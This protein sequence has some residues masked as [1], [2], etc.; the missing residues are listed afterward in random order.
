MRLW[1]RA[2]GAFKD[3]SS[4]WRANLTRRTFL[5]NPDIDKAI[6]RATSHRDFS[7]SADRHNLDIVCEWLRLS[8]HNLKPIL[9]SLSARMDRTRSWPVAL[10]GL[11]LTHALINCNSS[12]VS[13]IGRLPFDLSA[14]RDAHAPRAGAWPLNAFVRAY[15]AFL[16]QKSATAFQIAG[17]KPPEPPSGFAM[18]RELLSLQRLQ[19]LL[20]LLLAIKP[21]STA[22]FVPL[23]LDVMDGVIV[24]IYDVYGRICRGIAMVLLNIYSAG[25]AEAAVALAVVNKATKQGEDL[26]YFFQFCQEIRVVNAANFPAID[27]IPEEGIQ[28]LEQ[29][30]EELSTSDRFDCEDDDAIV[31]KES[32]DMDFYLKVE[33]KTVITDKWEKF[34]EDL[35]AKTA[36]VIRNQEPP[37]LITFV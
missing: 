1:K 21:A 15:Y 6:I 37:D 19:A 2:S 11:L 13:A 24:E 5:R 17:E 22:A 7:S 14:F 32:D 20:D 3:Q 33:F 28:E 10:K 29:I 36:V 23:V 30:I 16:D 35:V 31:A 26:T 12:A 4:L 8:P 34:D 25:K 27:R 18:R 9:R